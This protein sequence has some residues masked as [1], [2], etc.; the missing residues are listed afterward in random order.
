MPDDIVKRLRTTRW[1]YDPL[2]YDTAGIEAERLEAADR[3]EA[4]EKE[5]RQ[6]RL[7]NEKCVK[8]FNK[9]K[10]FVDAMKGGK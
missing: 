10:K 7:A 1:N 2:E 3:I 6:H 5:V 8:E 9:L 4:L